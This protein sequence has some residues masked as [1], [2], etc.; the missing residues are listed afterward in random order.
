MNQTQ[1][2]WNIRDYLAVLRRRRGV[3]VAITLI[4]AGLAFG[5]SLT[6]EETFAGEASLRVK[7]PG[8]EAAPISGVQ[9]TQRDFPAQIAAQA[10][11]RATS[12]DVIRGVRARL[13]LQDGLAE[14]Q[15]RV[16]ATQDPDS[17]LVTIRA[18]GPTALEAARLTNAVADESAKAAT[19]EARRQYAEDARDLRTLA[20]GERDDEVRTQLEISAGRLE[21]LSTITSLGE[22][23]SRATPPGAPE[24]PKPVRDAV[25]AGFFGLILGLVIAAILEAMDRRLRNPDEIQDELGLP[26]VGVVAD[27]VLGGVPIAGVPGEEHVAAMDMFRMLRTN[28]AF[29][30]VDHPSRRVLVTSS[31][32]NEGKTSVATG[33]A[34]A[35]AVTGRRTLLIETDLHRPVIAERLGIN[36]TPGLTDLIAGQAAPGEVL[37]GLR[38][39]DPASAIGGNGTEPQLATLSCITA[40]TRTGRSA[41]LLS[42]AR[43]NGFLDE[44]SKH[45]DLVVIDSG[46]ILAVAETLEVAPLVDTILFCVRLGQTTRDEA[47]RGAHALARLPER[48]TGLVITDLGAGDTGGY[49]YYSYAY[50]YRFDKQPT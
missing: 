35:S 38:F 41:E 17:N 4:A 21:A 14:I 1:R 15:S 2:P 3:I 22:V 12:T 11:T 18:E 48:T 30:D 24:S 46:P 7:D 8:L 34:L 40:G 43:F 13:G 50:S 37:Q 10:A 25:L 27:H 32:P 31:L 23:I 42:S 28:V 26:L 47:R 49:S 9:A 45:Y 44:V 36:A 19:D 6:R 33:L 16:S 20:S 29:L 39:A 5:S